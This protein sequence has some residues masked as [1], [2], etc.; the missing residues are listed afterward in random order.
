MLENGWMQEGEHLL[1]K[2]SPQVLEQI[3]AVGYKHIFAR[4]KGDITQ[5]ELVEKITTETWQLAKRQMTW[6]KKQLR[7]KDHPSKKKIIVL[8]KEIAEM[9]EK[10]KASKESCFFDQRQWEEIQNTIPT[11]SADLLGIY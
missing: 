6:I 1:E 11:F 2:Y 8:S 4:L 9:V 7:Q 3:N 10:N 5:K